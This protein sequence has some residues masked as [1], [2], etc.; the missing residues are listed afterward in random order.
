MKILA[1]F[2]L[3]TTF[4]SCSHSTSANSSNEASGGISGTYIVGGAACNYQITINPKTTLF[5][6]GTLEA[7]YA[8]RMVPLITFDTA[9][10]ARNGFPAIIDTLPDT[11]ANVIPPG[12][13]L[14]GTKGAGTWMGVYPEHSIEVTLGYAP[15]DTG[16]HWNNVN[17]W[18]ACFDTVQ[19]TFDCWGPDNGEP[20]HGIRQ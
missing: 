5:P 7:T 12:T 17:N 14:A 11:G 20:W 10:P 2:F 8:G 16:S 6:N 19:G 3:I 1:L 15:D 9:A 4:C 13:I 18:D